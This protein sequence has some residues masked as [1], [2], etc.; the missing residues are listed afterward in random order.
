MLCHGV[1]TV[2]YVVNIRNLLFDAVFH[3]FFSLEAVFLTY[4]KVEKRFG[5]THIYLCDDN[6]AIL[7]ALE[8]QLREIA[9]RHSLDVFITA[10]ESGE[11]LLF[12][13]DD[14]DRTVDVIFLDIVMAGYNGLDTAKKLRERGCKAELVF[15]TAKPEYVFDSFEVSPA[16]YILK[17]QMT[18][19]RLEE[20]FLKAV[21]TSGKKRKEL[22][23]C[24]NAAVRRNIPVSDI[25]YFEVQNRKVTVY[26]NNQ[27][28]V[29]YAS[30]EEVEQRLASDVFVRIHRSY[31]V[32]LSY[33]EGIERNFI[34]LTGEIRLPL[35][36]TY[37]KKVKEAMNHYFGASRE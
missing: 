5:M 30:L 3:C 25:Y 11:Q 16:Y 19:K 29:F 22:F 24:E 26:Y 13:L 23:T 2:F 7:S 32:N 4:K 33:V 31:L 21:S 15:L 36:I 35:G 6:V 28:F 20:V 9:A 34:V 37:V 14:M 8:E 10:C 27:S 12:H 1:N 17:N 18:K